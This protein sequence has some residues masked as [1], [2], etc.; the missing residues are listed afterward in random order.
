MARFFLSS[1]RKQRTCEIQ[2]ENKELSR[3]C[4]LKFVICKLK[5]AET[6]SREEL[7]K[8][9]VSLGWR[10]TCNFGVLAGKKKV[11]FPRDSLAIRSVT[12]REKTAGVSSLVQS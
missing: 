10:G 3:T 12:A 9:P 6:N 8:K 2:K 1:E 5:P 4:N 7:Q 11:L